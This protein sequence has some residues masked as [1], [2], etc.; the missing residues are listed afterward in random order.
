MDLV[1]AHVEVEVPAGGPLDLGLLP[2]DVVG[3]D[4]LPLLVNWLWWQ[5]GAER[6]TGQ[7]GV[8]ALPC[9]LVGVLDAEGLDLKADDARTG[10]GIVLVILDDEPQVVVQVW[11]RS[12]A[13]WVC[14]NSARFPCIARICAC[15]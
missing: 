10:E 5:V 3:E 7:L 9:T 14:T 12:S 13:Q 2:G 11:G 4:H 8:L 1:I 6:H 15:E